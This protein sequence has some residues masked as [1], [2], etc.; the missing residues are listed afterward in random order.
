MSMESVRHD[1]SRVVEV[2]TATMVSGDLL[3]G[4]VVGVISVSMTIERFTVLS[5]SVLTP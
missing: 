5:V 3:V 1:V 2:L 4:R